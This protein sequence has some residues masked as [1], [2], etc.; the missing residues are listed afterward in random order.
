M[1]GNGNIDTHRAT[2]NFVLGLFKYGAIASAV[3]AF[4][5]ILLIKR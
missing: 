4:I 1:S 3:I 5:V 2:Y